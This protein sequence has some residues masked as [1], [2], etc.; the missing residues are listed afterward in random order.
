MKSKKTPSTRV[1]LLRQKA[2][3]ALTT[4]R[5]QVKKMAPEKVQQLVH[6]LQVHQIEL[7]MQN[8]ELRQT[9]VELEAARDRYATL[10]DST[11]VGNVT[12]DGTGRI[13][14]ANLTLCQ[15]VGV[16]RKD[17]LRQKFE[18][19]L[20]P[21]DQI[22]FR[23]HLDDLKAKAG[24]HS[25][26]VLT[27]RYHKNFHRVRLE[28]SLEMLESPDR[29]TLFRV[30]VLDVTEH[31]R[32]AAAKEEEK[33]LMDMVVGSVQEAI[34][35]TD[36]NEVIVL[37]NKGAEIMFRCPALSAL[38]Q[39]VDRF[40]PERFRVAHHRHIR[41]F[42]KQGEASRQ[43]GLAR[44]ITGLRS[45]GE[46]FPIEA[47]ISQV[48]VK[49][50]KKKLFTVVLRDLT[51]R[52]QAQKA[53]MKERKFISEILDTVA[54][55]VVVLNPQG[56]IVQ[57]NPA[58]EALTGFSFEEIRG[59]L[60]WKKLLPP[61]DPEQVKEYFHALVQGNAP[62]F[63][64][65]YW[66]TKDGNLRWIAWSNSVLRNERGVVEFVIATGID[67]TKQRRVQRALKKE[68]RFIANVL[69][70]AGALVIILNPQWRVLHM[71]RVCEQTIQH[72]LQSLRGQPFWDLLV[73]A[74]E[75]D[76][77]ARQVLESYKADRLPATFESA[78]LDKSHRL[79]WI[80]WNTTASRNK[81]G[82]VEYFI[83]TGT[84]ITD[85]KFAERLLQQNEERL[86]AIL[87]HSPVS[88]WLKDLDGR[89]LKVNRQFERNAGLPEKEIVGKT[90]TQIFSAERAAR[91]HE[92][93]QT[94]LHTR[95]PYE[96]DE[97][98]FRSDGMH[99]EHV[100]KFLI[101]NA[102]GK[103]SA[104]CGI[105]TDITQR[106]Q[107]ERILQETSQ[108]LEIQQ[109]ELRS[110]A[111][112]LLMAQEEERR[113]IS[114]DLHDDVNQ[115]LALLS[116]KLENAQQG[117]SETH[118][119]RP[120]LQE[121][122]ECVGNLSDDIRH[123]AYQYH[124]SILDDLGLGTALRSLCEDFAKWEGVAV[125]WELPDGIGKLSQAVSTC[126]YRVAQE[127]LRNVSRHA[128]ASAVHLVLKEDGQGMTL[129]IRDNGQGFEVDGLL[130]KG[131]GFVSMRERAHLV[132]G[133]LTVESQPGQGATV[134][135]SIPRVACT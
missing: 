116:L 52:Q 61:T 5:V 112:Q 20:E 9:Q 65:N 6:E 82:A 102:Q 40:I 10:F 127:S 81:R 89:Y 62:S 109:Q 59:S 73:I 92:I 50:K 103:P 107:A 45:D 23:R 26:D 58:C 68:Q 121:L 8:E 76:T 38:G 86:Q 7:E 124:P 110:L 17:I 87:D 60:W 56:H 119:V 2:E 74:R 53:L 15:L 35:T 14:E 90:E 47:T 21:E 29:E 88:I 54:A 46:E 94:L 125:T 114:R 115:R 80:Q 43:M 3:K 134:N 36:E 39:P 67:L 63:H 71:N 133:T 48:E 108:R 111:S 34:V 105:A 104:L 122:Y 128:Q 129:S 98:S 78:I 27:M 91:F 93:D 69:D 95:R 97:V 132:S 16:S 11:P 126:L 28:S 22:P 32:I 41:Q 12:L 31:E 13:L 130:S 44:E 101:T 33:V 66:M 79:R 106:K 19:F 85:R 18:E 51:E 120:K 64:E 118:P 75:D 4:S 42:G 70:T 84:D 24:T 99:I 77:G 49:G 25:S 100:V 96:F 30:T 1:S 123:L 131:L 117:L 55:L 57:F 135:I 113:R 83:A 72:S 37:F